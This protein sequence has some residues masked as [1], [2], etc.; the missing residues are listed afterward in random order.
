MAE[1]TQVHDNVMRTADGTPLKVSIARAM[2]RNK[3]K[4]LALIAPL[5]ERP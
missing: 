1:A 3:L 4:A 2:R 5:P